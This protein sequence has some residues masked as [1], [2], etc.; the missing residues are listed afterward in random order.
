MTE[1][2][3]GDR[4]DYEYAANI[5]IMFTSTPLLQRPT[6]A[7]RAGFRAIECWWPFPVPDPAPEQLTAFTDAVRDAGVRLTGL[8]FFAGDMPAGERGVACRPDRTDELTVSIDHLITI[9]EATG[10]R[11]FN[12]LYG[13]YD[14][15]WSVDDQR[16]TAVTAIGEAAEAVRGIG[17]TVL[18][19]PLAAPINGAYPLHSC[20]DVIELLDGPLAG[21]QNIALL[22]DLFHLG[23]NGADLIAEAA[24]VAP[25]IGH[26]QVADHPGRHEPGTG[27]LP[28]EA[29]LQTLWQAGYRGRIGCE[30]QP[31]GR[32]EDG[33][34]WL[35]DG[36]LT[37][38]D[39]HH[40]KDGS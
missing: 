25:R 20:D 26:V 21:R 5:S 24:R 10:C 7:A 14:D 38:V 4:A 31:T 18:L 27:A 15:R 1:H 37:E 22:F 33:L 8:N 6:A 36:A 40:D 35:P 39:H 16:R 23:A 11:L 12:L 17:G 19:E 3:P 13:Q 9:A 2:R 28:I 29:T 34:G 30:Y 32:T